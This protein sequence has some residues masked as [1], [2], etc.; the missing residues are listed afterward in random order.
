[1][2]LIGAFQA[3]LLA[4]AVV[5]II[6]Q[7]PATAHPV[8]GEV[9][10]VRQPDGELIQ[11]RIWGDEF[12]RVVESLDGYTL[13]PDPQTRAACYARLSDDGQELVSTGVRVGGNVTALNLPKGIRIKPEAA[14]AQARAAR[15]AAAEAERAILLDAGITTANPAP[16]STGNVKGICLI[17][18][19]SDDVATV[20]RSSIDSYLN[21]VGYT[22]YGNNGSVRDYFYAVS[23][24]KLT[25]TN[26]VPAAYYRAQ[27]P[28]TYYEDENV[29]YGTRA[30]E[31]ITEALNHLNNSGFD[32]SQYDSNGDGY[33]DGINCLYAGS[34]RN[35]W[36]KG[37]WPHASSVSFQADGVRTNRYQ[38]TNIG[39]SLTLSTFCHEN[40]HMICGWPDLYDYGYESRGVGR[41]CIM[42][43]SA[44]STNP[45]E[46]CAYLKVTANW[47]TVNL[48]TLPQAG[49]SLAA[50][51]TN[52]CYKFPHPTRTNEYYLIENR[53]K[54]GRDSSLPDAGL[55]IWHIDTTGSNDREEMTPTSHYQV[56]LVQ[57]DGRW[58]L[59]RNQNYGDSTDLWAAPSHTLC[60]PTTN[61]DTN[62]WDTTISGLTI[63][64]ISASGA[65]MTFDFALTWDCNANGV[66]DEQDIANGTSTD[67]NG[68]GLPDECDI[69][70][71]TSEDCNNDGIPDSCQP[72]TDGDGWIDAC[73]NCPTTAN[74]DQIDTDGDGLGDACDPDD[75]NDEIPDESD[76]C[77][78]TVNVD[79]IDSDGDGVG[80][81]CDACP[82]TIPSASVD[83]NG[84][85]P[86]IRGDFDRDGDVDQ[87]DFGYLQACYS[88]D[89]VPQY[90]AAC[91]NAKLDGDAD[92]DANDL[93]LFLSCWSGPHSPAAA[94]CQP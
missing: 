8:W 50:S 63:R 82:N 5:L 62:W 67:C 37:L 21:Q 61:P 31:L 64:N 12:Y 53:Q 56:T 68:N 4:G 58:D 20:P 6:G 59:E 39:S 78:R 3:A 70:E 75:D 47:A 85:P 86:A 41:F 60:S 19:F 29:S 16:P 48:L 14:A 44:S 52:V 10:E 88:G 49:L 23:D 1:M 18:D 11:V 79:Q 69:D 38:I 32:F 54:T 80:D 26:Y 66:S 77:P 43:Y 13:V 33:V 30:R 71:G 74:L 24:G 17:V 84:C 93:A 22:G 25:Y 42:C 35:A 81:A 76:N 55:A 72:D 7:P 65:T 2:R 90:R 87:A 83:E 73:D 89:S 91:A 40:G 57:A 15:E 46:P 51:S 94:D 36:S 92:V 27:K 45:Q 28:K 9:F 34:V